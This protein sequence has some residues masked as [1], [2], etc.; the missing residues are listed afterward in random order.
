MLR[1]GLGSG[2]EPG[3]WARAGG[4]V[5]LSVRPDHQAS[6]L[7]ARRP[8]AGHSPCTKRAVTAGRG[9]LCG[10]PVSAQ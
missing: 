2:G 1:L 10:A 4:C 5:L 9:V 7:T 3:F 6:M 8:T